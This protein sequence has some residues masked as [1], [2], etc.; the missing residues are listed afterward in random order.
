MIAVIWITAAALLTIVC[1][2]YWYATGAEDYEGRHRKPEKSCTTNAASTATTAASPAAAPRTPSRAPGA[3]TEP[4]RNRQTVIIPELVPELLPVEAAAFETVNPSA[5]RLAST[6][7][8]RALA[9]T[10]DMEHIRSEI[11][12]FKA[13]LR[14]EE[15]T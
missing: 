5:E 13:L 2:V 6:G 3:L 8:L 14:L 15:W 10:G 9:Y 12:A 11:A 1:V 4:R 7:E